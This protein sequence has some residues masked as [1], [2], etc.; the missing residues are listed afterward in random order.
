MTDHKPLTDAAAKALTALLE[1][2]DGIL[3]ERHPQTFHSL[4]AP[5]TADALTALEAALGAPLPPEIRALIGWH[6]GQSMHDPLWGKTWRLVSATEAATFLRER[7][8]GWESSWVP[9][10]SDGCGN[11]AGFP[12][13]GE[14]LGKL[15][16]WGHEEP[17][18]PA[19]FK[20]A[21]LH[22][23]AQK[24]CAARRKTRSGYAGPF[25][26]W[27]LSD[28][29]FQ[30][31]PLK[32]SP[33]DRGWIKA[34]PAGVVLQAA[35]SRRRPNTC[36]HSLI[37]LGKN[38]WATSF[39]FGDDTPAARADSGATLQAWLEKKGVA[40]DVECMKDSPVANLLRRL[41]E[42]QLADV[43]MGWLTD[44]DLDLTA[45]SKKRTRLKDPVKLS[46]VHDL[47]ELL[48]S[49]KGITELAIVD[50]EALDSEGL[51]A[52]SRVPGIRALHLRRCPGITSVAPL[53]ALTQLEVLTIVD[54]PALADEG[55]P[56]LAKLAALTRL[57]V[58]RASITEAAL[59]PLVGIEPLRNVKVLDCPLVF[60]KALYDEAGWTAR[61]E[62]EWKTGW[63]GEL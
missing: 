54:C 4:G 44:L 40:P 5:A 56:G 41:W 28:V 14:G 16:D 38:A 11:Y 31:E 53:A 1:E 51:A 34:L 13:Q 55:W 32:R 27:T 22:E 33:G 29:R 61:W 36:C 37:K 19:A 10:L 6:D 63:V 24:A 30:D 8:H 50:S 23:W 7:P 47:E 25:P 17:E 52:L 20:V 26:D 62:H 2:L 59:R 39:G 12:T 35:T 49:A 58:E 3:K 9:V 60:S 48:A 45:L 42:E 46:R 21:T 18:A 15:L 57:Y 43:F